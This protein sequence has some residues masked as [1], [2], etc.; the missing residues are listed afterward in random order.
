MKK[1][2]N[3]FKL[4]SQHTLLLPLFLGDQRLISHKKNDHNNLKELSKSDVETIL[5]YIQLWPQRLVQRK[6][7]TSEDNISQYFFIIFV[8]NV[9][10]VIVI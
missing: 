5:A 9:C 4:N 7:S 8:G 10:V 1:F 6:K 2:R 3:L